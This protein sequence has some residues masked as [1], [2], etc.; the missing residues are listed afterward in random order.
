MVRAMRGVMI[1]SMLKWEG[2]EGEREGCEG[3]RG[4]VGK[5]RVE[6][7]TESMHIVTYRTT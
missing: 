6:K 7:W 1:R 3:E 2:C 5:R 4:G